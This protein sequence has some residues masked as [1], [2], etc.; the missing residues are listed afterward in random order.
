MRTC[1][2]TSCW[3]CLADGPFS[4]LFCCF[5]FYFFF[6]QM[7]SRSLTILWH[8]RSLLNRFYS[9]KTAVFFL[10]LCPFL[11]WP[12][13]LYFPGRPILFDLLLLLLSVLVDA[14]VV[15]VVAPAAADCVFCQDEG[16]S[17][18]FAFVS[19]YRPTRHG[20][21]ETRVID[22]SC[23]RI[24]NRWYSSSSIFIFLCFILLCNHHDGQQHSRCPV[25]QIF[26]LL[27]DCLM[28]RFSS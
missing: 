3:T 6:S 14:V 25:G 21:K 12:F 28:A 18:L 10:V 4:F 15:V 24:T 5:T 27:L 1:G 19:F 2:S 23:Y 17:C 9:P 13:F 7:G 20:K 11:A 22:L 26:H 16:P 8:Q